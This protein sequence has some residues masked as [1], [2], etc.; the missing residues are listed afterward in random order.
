[1]I[2]TLDESE[3]QLLP[4]HWNK[5]AYKAAKKHGLDVVKNGVTK[6]KGTDGSQPKDRLER[7]GFPFFSG[8]ENIVIGKTNPFEVVFQMLIDDGVKSRGHRKNVLNPAH[9]CCGISYAQHRDRGAVYIITYAFYVASPDKGDMIQAFIEKWRRQ[10]EQEAKDNGWNGEGCL[11]SKII[12][13]FPNL[14]KVIEFPGQSVKL[15][16]DINKMVYKD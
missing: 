6:H 11:N 1:M 7:Y 15:A 13:E 12:F 14:V 16:K 8:A 9:R 10:D 5:Y 3:D 4:F 2:E